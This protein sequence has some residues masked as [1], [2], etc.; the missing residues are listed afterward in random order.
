[1]PRD[2]AG[3][4]LACGERRATRD[5]LQKLDVIAETHHRVIVERPV[6]SRCCACSRLSPCTISLAIIGS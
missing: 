4:D 5:A 3:V 2:E 6:A 1:M